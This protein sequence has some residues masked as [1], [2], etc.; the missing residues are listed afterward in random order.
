[1]LSSDNAR[2]VEGHAESTLHKV[3]AEL[4]KA[5][6][7]EQAVVDTISGMQNSGILFRERVPGEGLSASA[8]Y[9]DAVLASKECLDKAKSRLD[10]YE[11]LATEYFGRLKAAYEARD[12]AGVEENERLLK[13]LNQT[14]EQGLRFSNGLSQ[15]GIGYARL[16]QALQKAP[17]QRF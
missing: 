8:T 15:L 11:R 13:V 17:G 5:G 7:S 14:T 16:A 12:E 6:L 1:M 4:L 2:M 9:A 10:E 3:R